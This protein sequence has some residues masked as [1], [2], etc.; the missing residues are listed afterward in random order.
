MTGILNHKFSA[1]WYS[2]TSIYRNNRSKS[3]PL[4][5]LWNI[6]R[7]IIFGNLRQRFFLF[8]F[9]FLYQPLLF[10]LNLLIQFLAGAFLGSLLHQLALNGILQNARF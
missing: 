6:K 7:N 4:P 2:L 5:T 8:D 1:C 3:H 9:L 10:C